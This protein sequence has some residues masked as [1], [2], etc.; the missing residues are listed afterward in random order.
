LSIQDTD[1]ET[2]SGPSGPSRT[3]ARLL[4][5]GGALGAVALTASLAVGLTGADDV[6]EPGIQTPSRLLPTNLPTDFS[7]A[8]PTDMPSLQ[9]PTDLPSMPELPD[10]S[11]G[12]S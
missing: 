6:A 9:L 1:A 3:L 4:A 8:F 10:L 11:G 12:G 5:I 2:E 7:T